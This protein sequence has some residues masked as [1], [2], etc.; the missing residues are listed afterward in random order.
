LNTND[1]WTYLSAT[2]PQSIIIN[3]DYTIASKLL[4]KSL[5]GGYLDQLPYF[6]EEIPQLIELFCG[7]EYTLDLP[8]INDNQ[9]TFIFDNHKE[10]E[11]NIISY[12]EVNIKSIN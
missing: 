9:A 7:S 12:K 2:D 8:D 5:L 10:L 4:D 6:L 1:R 11:I 3:I